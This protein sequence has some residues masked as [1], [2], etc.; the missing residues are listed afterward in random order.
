MGGEGRESEAKAYQL[1]SR[2]WCA[3]LR[4]GHKD[5]QTT[6]LAPHTRRTV[7]QRAHSTRKEKHRRPMNRFQLPW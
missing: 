5:H 4:G 1:P 2:A 7:R 6:H 3:G